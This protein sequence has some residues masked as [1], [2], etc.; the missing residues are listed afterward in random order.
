MQVKKIQ[1]LIGQASG[2]AVRRLAVA[3][4]QDPDL[5]EAL[6]RAMKAGFI[7]PLLI[8]NKT[9]IIKIAE[10]AELNLSQVEIIHEPDAF[11]ACELSVRLVRQGHADLIMKGHVSTSIFIKHILD[12]ENGL[13]QGNLLSHVAFFET[14]YYHKM[15]GITD[16][17][18]NISPG[19]DDKIEIINNAVST[20]KKLGIMNPKIGILAAVEVVNEKMEATVHAARLKS[21]NREGRLKG[22]IV[23][24]PLALDNAI[25]AAAAKHKGIVS[26]VAGDADVLVAPDINSGNILYKSLSFLGGASVAA[27]V[28][29]ARVPVVL[30]SR[31]D[32]DSNKFYSIVLAAALL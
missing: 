10:S 5:I 29:G 27:V 12:K 9:E 25:S 6:I 16:A 11:R 30:T 7:S 26:D 15:L 20:C 18:L 8:G 19:L 2:N 17:A 3:A 14:Q 28:A 1:D 4:A 21:L 24:G 32:S 23:D 31:S 22:C 13:M